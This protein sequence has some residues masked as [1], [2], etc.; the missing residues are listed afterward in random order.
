MAAYIWRL[1][2]LRDASH[3]RVDHITALLALLLENSLRSVAIR[4]LC[5]SYTPEPPIQLPPAHPLTEGTLARDHIL[6]MLHSAYTTPELAVR[7]TH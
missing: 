2:F 4:V 3:V 7:D 5:K 1:Y 6:T